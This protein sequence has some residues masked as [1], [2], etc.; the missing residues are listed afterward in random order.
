MNARI[1]IIER[2]GKPEYAVVPIEIYQ[3]MAEALE[4]L[5]DIRAADEAMRAI[6]AGEDELVPA[7]TAR[8]LLHGGNPLKVWREHRDLS[9]TAL[10]GKAGISQAYLA[11]IET[12]N[13]QG[14]VKVMQAL[15]GALKVELD[16]LL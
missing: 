11:Q 3:R 10:A 14:S 4:D 9:Q 8:R 13:R 6:A 15:A 12:G 7:E 16:D 5:E 1:Q 2:D